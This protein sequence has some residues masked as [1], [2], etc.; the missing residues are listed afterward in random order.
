V[1]V[2]IFSNRRNVEIQSEIG[3][4]NLC[5]Y[6]RHHSA[7]ESDGLVTE[8]ILGHAQVTWIGP[9]L[10]VEYRIGGGLFHDDHLGP[11]EEIF[12]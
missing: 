4:E 1:D 12:F 8:D 7:A 2:E 5:R 11:D 10:I 3:S 9:G 6:N